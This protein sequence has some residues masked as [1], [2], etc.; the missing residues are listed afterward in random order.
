[1]SNLTMLSWEIIFE[2]VADHFTRVLALLPSL[3]PVAL[4]ELADAT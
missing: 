1:M 2:Q 3:F 4:L